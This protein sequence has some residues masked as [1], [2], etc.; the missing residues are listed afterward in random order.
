MFGSDFT[1][2][3]VHL[4][5]AIMAISIVFEAVGIAVYQV[6]QSHEKMWQSFFLIAIPRDLAFVCI[7][8]YLTQSY[9]GAGLAGA[10][11]VG[12]SLALAVKIT[13]AYKL[14]LHKNI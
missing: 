5:V 11:L 14:G 12:C 13:L 4:M 1:G 7:A 3:Y 2:D 10:F 8:F 9:G 6:I